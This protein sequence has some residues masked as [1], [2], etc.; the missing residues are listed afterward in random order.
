MSNDIPLD[1]PEGAGSGAAESETVLE[2]ER[3]S[4]RYGDLPAVSDLSLSVSRGEFFTLLGPS[5]CGKTT[6]LRLLAGLERPD[7]GTVRIGGETVAG[8][9]RFRSPEA[10]DVGLVFQDFALFPHLTVAENI[11]FGLQDLPKAERSERVEEMLTL[12]GMEGYGPRSVEG[13]SG[14]ERQRVA[15]AR[16]LAPRPD[17]VLLD[18]PFSNLDVRLRVEMREEVRRILK[19]LRVTVVSVTHDQEEALSMSDRVGVM[20]DGRLAQVGR[21]EAV[22]ESPDSRFVASFLGQANFVPG[23]VDA[24]AVRTPLGTFDRGQLRDPPDDGAE[25]SVL[26]RPDDLIARSADIPETNGQVTERQYTGPIFIYRVELDDGTVVGCQHNHAEDFDV[27]ERVRV[28]LDAQHPL[29]WY[30]D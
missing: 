27:G 12:T 19:V 23:E 5:G 8:G 18:E 14:G 11:A 25:I 2:L 10:R 3:V 9:S 21:P 30:P 13:L 28:D 17:V 26:A 1:L 15:L 20:H 4:K 6:T 22:F 29:A 7:E 16:S 24:E